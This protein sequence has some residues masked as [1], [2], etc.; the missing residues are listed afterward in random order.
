MNEYYVYG[1]YDPRNGN[2]FYIGKGKKNRKDQHFKEHSAPNGVRKNMR[3]KEIRDAGYEP[4]SRV[5]YE[6]LTENQAWDNEER[7]IESL[8]REGIDEGGIL[9]NNHTRRQG[10]V[11]TEDVCRAISEKRQGIE[12]SQ[13]TRKKMSDA[14]KGKTW[15][16]IFGP[17]TAAKMR[18][19]KSQKRGPC[20]EET[21][22][23]IS[24]ARLGQRVHNWS[25]ESRRKL[26]QTNKG[27]PAH[28]NLIAAAK[29]TASKQ[30]ECPHCGKIGKGPAMRRWHF[31]Y[32]KEKNFAQD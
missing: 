24:E 12:F 31:E 32:C 5:L 20:P 15:E 4:Y 19:R 29:K 23:K 7:L 26:S 30:L 8:G 16:E 21:R 10:I 6:N 3:I 11:M 17:D 14:K 2:P 25:E 22:K 1:L 9:T 28:P 27:K 13:D 18:E